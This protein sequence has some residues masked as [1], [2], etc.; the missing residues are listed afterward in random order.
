MAPAAPTGAPSRKAVLWLSFA[1]FGLIGAVQALYGPAFP[2]LRERFGIGLGSV[3]IA[4]SAQFFGAF[5]GIVFSGLLLRAFGYRRALLAAAAALAVGGASIALAPSWVAVL[6]GAVLTG[7]GA[8]LLN[9]ACTL[10][11]AVV[12]SPKA[13]PALNL[14]NAAFGVGAVAG[15]LLIAATEPR[16]GWPFAFIALGSLA[17]LPW[18]A[19]MVVPSVALPDRAAA[20]VAWRSLAAF[21]VLYVFYVSAEVGVTSWETEYLAPTFGPRAAAFTSLYWLA[22]TVGRLLAVPLSARVRTHQLVLYAT[23]AALIFMLAAHRVESAPIAFVLVGLSLAPIFPTT[24]AWLTE[25]FPR[26]AEQVTPVVVAAANLG[27]ALSA[28]VIGAVV[29]AQG[30]GVVPSA[31]SG[32]TLVLLLTVTWLWLRTRGRA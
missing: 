10:M 18:L 13:A 12:F 4:V 1:A 21:V 27:P 14:V 19:R 16:Y 8:G 5:A 29:S 26:R 32:L 17:L 25:V 28:P 30:V 22:I 15:P 20:P 24:L 9:V 23:A 11:V 6:A 2:L 31:L 3:S 7:A